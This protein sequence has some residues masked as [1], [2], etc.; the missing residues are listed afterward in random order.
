MDFE[1]NRFCLDNETSVQV[2]QCDYDPLTESWTQCPPLKKKV[3]D[4]FSGSTTWIYS[5]FTAKIQTE[6][7]RLRGTADIS[8]CQAG[9]PRQTL[10]TKSSDGCG[11]IYRYISVSSVIHESV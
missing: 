1:I 9:G 11:M 8:V 5:P 4:N 7:R 2:L 10:S 6:S 3:K